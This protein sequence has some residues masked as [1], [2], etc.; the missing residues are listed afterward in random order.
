[1]NELTPL[2]DWPMRPAP[3]SFANAPNRFQV[4][5]YAEFDRKRKTKTKTLDPTRP[6]HMGAYVRA[7]IVRAD[8]YG[9]TDD[10]A[11]RAKKK[12]G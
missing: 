1:M 12:P 7:P 9:P 11:A 8:A 5:R 3:Q 10:D 2:A 4:F 6:V